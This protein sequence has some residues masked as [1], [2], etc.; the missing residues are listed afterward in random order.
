MRTIIRMLVCVSL[1]GGVAKAAT[2]DSAAEQRRS[3]LTAALQ[4]LNAQPP[5]DSY[6]EHPGWHKSEVREKLRGVV[7]K[8]PN[9]EEAITAELWLA[10]AELETGQASGRAKK[11]ENM[12]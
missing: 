2:K 10:T 9:T 12:L 5:P 11:S 8:Y 4:E 1:V 6:E 3:D 7:A